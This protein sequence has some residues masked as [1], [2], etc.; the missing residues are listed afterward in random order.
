MGGEVILARKTARSKQRTASFAEGGPPE[1][2]GFL[3]RS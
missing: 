3:L 2:A 1:V